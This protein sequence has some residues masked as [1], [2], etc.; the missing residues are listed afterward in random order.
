MARQI[1]LETAF[2]PNG[3][4]LVIAYKA[5]DLTGEYRIEVAPS[6]IENVATGAWVQ[7][8]QMGNDL[9]GAKKSVGFDGSPGFQYRIH[10][11]GGTAEAVDSTAFYWD[12]VTRLQTGYY[13][14]G[15]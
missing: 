3:P 7:I 6:Q 12:D 8:T 13:R 11:E 1:A 14:D 9:Q 4:F 10:R 5:S 2:R 15:N